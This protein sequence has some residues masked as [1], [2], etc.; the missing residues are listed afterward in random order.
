MQIFEIIDSYLLT[1]HPQ[2]RWFHVTIAVVVLSL[3]VMVVRRRG[4]GQGN[5][6][7]LKARS[8]AAID[9]LS[10]ITVSFDGASDPSSLRDRLISADFGPKGVDAL[11]ADLSEN[12][13]ERELGDSQKVLGYVQHYYLDVLKD[14]SVLQLGEHKPTVWIMTGV[15][16]S[17]KTTTT[18]K[19]A[20]KFHDQ[21]LQV[22]VGACDTFRAA[23][24]EQ[25]VAWGERIGFKVITG[26]E[27][28][29]PAAVAH[30]TVASA[31]ASGADLVLLDTAGR[32]HAD[33]GLMREL[34]KIYR[35][36][37]KG[38]GRAVDECLIVL[39]VNQGQNIRSQMKAFGDV[40][41]LSGVVLSKYDGTGRGGAA[42]DTVV[43]AALPVRAIGI[44]EGGDDLLDAD[45]RWIVERIFGPIVA[46]V[47]S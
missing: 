2:L 27:R 24:A 29:D 15:N 7:R 17:G 22:T 40:V 12:L 11:L 23:A 6:I 19:L 30:N 18:A 9:A 33:E 10:S 1:F 44:G 20:K 14:S 46:P 38:L 45:A 25:L 21:G 13:S 4:S 36:A 5:N 43:D 31:I 16:G 3:L 32:L 26:G 39:D 34:E 42:I 37:T 41:P 28:S 35:V 8:G 47:D